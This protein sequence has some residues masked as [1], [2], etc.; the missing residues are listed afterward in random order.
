MRRVADGKGKKLEEVGGGDDQRDEGS[1]AGDNTSAAKAAQAKLRVALLRRDQYCCITGEDDADLLEA[2]Y[3]LTPAYAMH[4]FGPLTKS[5]RLSN[6]PKS[7][8]PPGCYDVKNALLL[9]DS[10]R[11][12]LHA[13]MWSPLVQDGEARAFLFRSENLHDVPHNA[14]LVKPLINPHARHPTHAY[15]QF[16]E[17]D[18]LMEH[19][20]QAVLRNCR[21]Q[22]DKREEFWDAEG[23]LEVAVDESD[24]E[25][26]EGIID[27]GADIVAGEGESENEGLRGSE[28][29]DKIL[30]RGGS[31]VSSSVV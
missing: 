20:K 12:A 30:E 28:V 8:F 18:V 1:P 25:M 21:G 19:F 29:F 2:A 23:A 16:P 3:V 15:N 22:G 26:C 9:K 13:F 11:D 10:V 4:Y 31:E 27:R 24:F 17:N 6:L 5:R 7:T 14:L